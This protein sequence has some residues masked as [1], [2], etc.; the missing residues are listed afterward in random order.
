MCQCNLPAIMRTA[1]ESSKNPGRQFWTCSQPRDSQ[2]QFFQW[3]DATPSDDA[4][5]RSQ[6]HNDS[7]AYDGPRASQP[8]NLGPASYRS[9]QRHRGGDEDEVEP[10]RCNCDLIASVKTVHKEG[11][12][13]DRQFYSCGKVRLR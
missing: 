3:T 9:N 7:S 8:L 5:R 4:P 11:E 13:K 10:P 6:Y 12:N 1:G 2:C